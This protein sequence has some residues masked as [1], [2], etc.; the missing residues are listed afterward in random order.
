M[1][2]RLGLG[3]LEERLEPVLLLRLGDV[4]VEAQRG[5]LRPLRILEPVKRREA[6][7]AHEGQRLVEVRAGLA[8]EAHDDVRGERQP[9]TCG[10]QR[11]HAAHVLG[12]GVPPDHA[13]E[14]PVAARLH[15]P[16][17]VLGEHRQVGVG[18]HQRRR[19]VPRV[20]RGVPKPIERRG[21]RGEL[22]E[23][24]GKL[25]LGGVVAEHRRVDEA[26]HGLPEQRDLA[27]AAGDEGAHLAHDVL[28]GAVALGA[29]GVRHDAERAALV[30]ALHHRHVR[31]RSDGAVAHLVLQELRVVE[32]VHGPHR[33]GRAEV[34]VAHQRRELGEV[35]G[36]HHRVDEGH[37]AHDALALLLRDAARDDEHGPG[38]LQ[39]PGLASQLLLG[40]LSHRAGVEDDH[41]GVVDVVPRFIAVRAH[42]L[43]D[44]L[45]VVDVHLAP[46]GDHR[47]ALLHGPR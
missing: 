26:V 36:A 40:L 5:R 10:L 9:W 20:R 41:V 4:V 22:P 39:T 31:A 33:R 19:E 3:D 24:R 6:D 28:R 43:L 44:P 2:P 17:H 15:G 32:V 23:Q 18:L 29:A 34:G 14:H 21:R 35:V 42:D 27:G 8:R 7:L 30:A 38:A 13:L 1:R 47:Q 45:R 16:V 12:A 37:V 25:R 46:E 11:R